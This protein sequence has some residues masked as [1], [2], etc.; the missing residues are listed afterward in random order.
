MILDFLKKQTLSFYFLIGAILALILQIIFY[1][2]S[3][4]NRFAVSYSSLVFIMSAI[5]IAI[6]I[7]SIIFKHILIEEIM[8]LFTLYSF[9]AFIGSQANYL[10]NLFVSIDDSAVSAGFVLTIVFSVIAI[11]LEIASFFFNKQK[12]DDVVIIVDKN[13]GC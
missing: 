13:E 5:A 4:I 2:T 8:F 12:K 11:G 1:A 3:G 7:V 10:A 6:G 9:I